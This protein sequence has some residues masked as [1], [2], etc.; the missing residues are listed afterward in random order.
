MYFN[1]KNCILHETLLK[2]HAKNNKIKN[3]YFIYEKMFSFE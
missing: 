1:Q 3:I 2:E